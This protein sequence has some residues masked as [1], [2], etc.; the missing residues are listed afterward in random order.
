MSPIF[1]RSLDK[2]TLNITSL[3]LAV[4]IMKTVCQYN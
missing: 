4:Y 3:F 1:D 2:F